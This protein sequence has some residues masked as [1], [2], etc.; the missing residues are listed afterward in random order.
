VRIISGLHKSIL[1]QPP[2][3]LPVRPTTDRAK[4]SLFNIIENQYDIESLK[5]LD[6]FS[7]TGNIAYEFASRGA[8]HVTAVDLSDKCV[9]FIKSMKQKLKLEQLN[10]VRKDAFSF[11]KTTPDTFDFIFADAPYAHQQLMQ[12]PRLV[13]ERQLLNQQGCLV[14][15]H[16]TL[17]DLSNE[18]GF[19]D[20]RVYGQSA[21]SFFT[22]S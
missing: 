11:L 4:E 21:F 13:M 22:A 2:Q 10:V 6:L 19:R 1:I 20:K 3:G 14:V 7:G 17:L 16:E 15:E 12:L 5:V 9:A 8:Q 18:P